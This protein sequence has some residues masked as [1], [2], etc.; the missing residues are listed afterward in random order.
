MARICTGNGEH[1]A[2]V[3]GAV[4]GLLQRWSPGMMVAWRGVE[5]SYG[6]S[7]ALFDVRLSAKGLER[8]CM[9]CGWKIALR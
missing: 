6:R 3:V 7:G 4:P 9:Y 1:T 8:I 5:Q 2:V